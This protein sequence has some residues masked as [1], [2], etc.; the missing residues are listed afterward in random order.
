MN[1]NYLVIGDTQGPFHHDKTIPFLKR[2]KKEFKIPKENVLHCGDE[3][4]LCFMGNYPKNPNATYTPTGELLAAREFIKELGDVFPIMRIAISNHMLRSARKA[5]ACEIPS[6]V[7][8][9]YEEIIAAPEGWKWKERWE[10]DTRH[11]VLLVHGM[12]FSSMY[13]YRQAPQM[14]GKSVAFGHLHTNG[15]TAWVKTMSY[16]AWG[17]SC[18]CL[19]DEE[20][21]AFDYQRWNKFK[22]ALGSGVVLNDGRMPMFIPLDGV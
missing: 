11:P 6:M 12:E 16:D 1:N 9:S 19:I 10:I 22:P 15:G 2:L 13:A 20:K 4:D 5:S 18:G 21:Y 17:M 8:R 7:M 14:L 3:T